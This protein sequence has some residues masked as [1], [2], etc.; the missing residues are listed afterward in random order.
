MDSINLGSSFAETFLVFVGFVYVLF[1][2]FLWRKKKIFPIFF[3]SLVVID[4]FMWAN[5]MGNHNSLTHSLT[6]YFLPATI[7]VFGVV[8][9]KKKNNE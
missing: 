3:I 6:Y 8:S 9:L 1:L 7:V 4:I 5:F 2:V